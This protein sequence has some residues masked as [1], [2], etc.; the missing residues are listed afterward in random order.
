RSDDNSRAYQAEASI[1][2]LDSIAQDHVQNL[3]NPTPS[4]FTTGPLASLTQT[5]P[6]AA[7][8][9]TDH[10]E[11]ATGTGL[12]AIAALHRQEQTHLAEVQRQFMACE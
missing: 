10:G 8:G 4:L 9:G 5:K 3:F 1:Q 7:T 2:L 12:E 6:K 11:V